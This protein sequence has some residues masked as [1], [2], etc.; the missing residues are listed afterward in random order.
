ME[1]KLR[2]RTRVGRLGRACEVVSA[3]VRMPQRDLQAIWGILGGRLGQEERRVLFWGATLEESLRS[4]AICIYP[5][6]NGRPTP[7][8]NRQIN[9]ESS[10]TDVRTKR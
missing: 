9:H 7:N 6:W 10:I 8:L 2:R 4:L 1:R 5:F 3:E